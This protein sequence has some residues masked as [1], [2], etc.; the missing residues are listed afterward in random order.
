MIFASGTKTYFLNERVSGESPNREQRVI[1]HYLKN[2]STTMINQLLK[3]L[4]DLIYGTGR[5][6]RRFELDHPNEKVLAADA[7]KGIVTTTNQDIQRGLDWVTSQRAVVLLTD[8]KIICGK[9]TIPLDT[10]SR[11]QL[12]KIHSLFGSGQVLK[13]QTTDDKN[14]QFGM[15]LNPEWTNQQRLPLTL[16]KGQVKYSAFSVVVRIIAVGYLIYWLYE[17][18]IAY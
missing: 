18:F 7:S 1:G 11:A 2:D 17:R 15:Q 9:W 5:T 12:F 3:G 16:E 4:V 6:R 13:V 8:Q 10:I 14:Y